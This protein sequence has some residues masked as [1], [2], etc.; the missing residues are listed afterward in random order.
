MSRNRNTKKN[1]P[2]VTD[3]RKPDDDRSS[4]GWWVARTELSDIH[5]P[6]SDR[7]IRILSA[8]VAALIVLIILIAGYFFFLRVQ[9]MQS[10]NAIFQNL[11]DMIDRPF[12]STN[13]TENLNIAS[14]SEYGL[15]ILTAIPLLEDI[16]SG[17]SDIDKFSEDMISTQAELDTLRSGG[18]NLFLTGN[19]SELLNQ[20][21][22]L[23]SNLKTLG[24]LGTSIRN[25]ESQF[26]A[27]N[28][29]TAVSFF[30]TGT[31]LQRDTD[32]LDSLITLLQQPNSHVLILFE[33][34]SIERPGGGRIIAYADATIAGGSLSGFSV[35][36]I[37]SLQSY[38]QKIVP[39]LQLQ[40]IE[41]SWKL[42]DTDWFADFP[43]SASEIL[44]R[45]ENAEQAEGSPEQ[46]SAVIAITPQVI[47]NLVDILG[48]I[49]LLDGKSLTAVN[50]NSEI[51]QLGEVGFLRQFLLAL[52]G[53][54]ANFTSDQRANLAP[55]ALD[56][57]SDRDVM[58]YFTDPKLEELI[59]DYN[60]GGQIYPISSG[61]T[62][63]YLA[64]THTDIIGNSDSQDSLSLNST[65]GSDGTIENDLDITR[66]NQSDS[67]NQEY[68]QVIVPSGSKLISV[69]GN[70]H[71][72]VS[73]PIN[74]AN[75]NYIE[76]PLVQ[77]I[78]STR[79]IDPDSL[80]ESYIVGNN[81]VFGFWLSLLPG[82]TQTVSVTYDSPQITLQNGENYQFVVERQPGEDASLIYS[83]QAPQGWSWQQAN[84]SNYLYSSNALSGRTI[85]NINLEHNGS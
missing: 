21:N 22:A 32:G 66:E 2:S 23:D 75:S 72:T 81:T 68:F 24:T 29:G 42:S 9:A 65:I 28:S 58:V 62:G 54:A 70:T 43:T 33:N 40:T 20:L 46:Y 73:P 13:S 49:Q 51:N 1:K 15:N 44:N 76:D 53:Q 14:S 7:G 82:V 41:T 85:L 36:N 78:E 50:L 80:A 52:E 5:M 79:D 84:S 37:S 26:N 16:T 8:C 55:I 10:T 27:L 11:S 12:S 6:S 34:T 30:T 18:L 25:L 59:N 60:A 63:D 56:W 31:D 74:Y 57:I 48:P 35:G 39:P 4:V 61:Y 83:L 64:V 77:K 47:S 67:L 71:N 19:G 3:I 17:F 69:I 38:D 45:F